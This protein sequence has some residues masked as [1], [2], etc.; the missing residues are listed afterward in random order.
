LKILIKKISKDLE[1][2][3]ELRLTKEAFDK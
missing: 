1:E 2:A 3:L